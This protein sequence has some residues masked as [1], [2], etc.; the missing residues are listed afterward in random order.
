MVAIAVSALGRLKVDDLA[1]AYAENK[2]AIAV[3]A[4]GRLKDH[5]SV[6]QRCKTWLGRDRRFSIRHTEK[7]ALA[8]FDARRL[9]FSLLQKSSRS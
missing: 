7:Y 1:E 6:W 2:V 4:L 5:G 8:L 3:S 9:K